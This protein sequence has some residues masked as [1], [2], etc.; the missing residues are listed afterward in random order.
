MFVDSTSGV[1]SVV[2][3]NA[4][5]GLAPETVAARLVD[6]VE[7]EL[8]AA[9]PEAPAIEVSHLPA[10]ELGGEWYWGNTSVQIQPA[11][12][13][14]TLSA[15]AEERTFRHLGDDAYLGL[16]GYYAGE[17]LQV[18]RRSDGAISHLEVVTF[19]L[20]RIP[21][22]PAAPIPGGPPGDPLSWPG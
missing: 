22:D 15:G 8:A 9:E 18:V 5:T 21:Y 17:R 10:A 11:E 20:T 19:V 7:P 13:G 16:D 6:L 1:G 4:M 3:T 2:L 14:F 12:A